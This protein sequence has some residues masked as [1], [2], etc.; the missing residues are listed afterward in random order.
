MNGA[1]E[2]LEGRRHVPRVLDRHD[3]VVGAVGGHHAEVQEIAG[4]GDRVGRVEELSPQ[5]L[6]A[7]RDGP[8]VFPRDRPGVP[9]VAI[10]VPADG[11][12]GR[13]AVGVV[14]LRA[15]T[16]LCRPSSGPR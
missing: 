11:R 4:V 16:S 15:S 5:G 14:E 3:V 7:G 9:G 8:Q 13:E 10:R 1:A 6:E 2:R 12:Q